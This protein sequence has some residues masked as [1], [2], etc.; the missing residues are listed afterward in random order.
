MSLSVSVRARN[1]SG[2]R[3]SSRKYG[4]LAR[5]ASTRPAICRSVRLSSASGV[6]HGCQSSSARVKTAGAVWSGGS[7]ILSGMIGG[8]SSGGGQDPQ[9]GG[10]P[11]L[12]R[13]K[14]DDL[15]QRHD[16]GGGPAGIQQR[17]Q[18][19]RLGVARM[20]DQEVRVIEGGGQT[21]LRARHD[22]S[23]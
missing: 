6:S 23:G 2:S 3:A 8:S 11:N 19:R 12:E 1:A 9:P 21:P 4:D 5:T 18:P 20:E 14:G 7:T 17:L 22:S 16:V 10:H 13:Q 15:R